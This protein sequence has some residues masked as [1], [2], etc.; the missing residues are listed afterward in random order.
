MAPVAKMTL[1]VG[2]KPPYPSADG[3]V[4]LIAEELSNGGFAVRLVFSE[5]LVATNPQ[6]ARSRKRYLSCTTPA[7]SRTFTVT[8]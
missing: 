5:A 8:P 1:R 4:Q 6:S 2:T 7:P 3:Q